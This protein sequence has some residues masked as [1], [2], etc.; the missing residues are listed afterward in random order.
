[1]PMSSGTRAPGHAAPMRNLDAA[2]GLQRRIVAVTFAFSREDYAASEAAPLRTP[3]S[4]CSMVRLATLGHVRK[5]DLGLIRCPG[6]RRALGLV[7][8]D[9]DY[10]S[11]RRYFSLGLYA[12]Q[13]RARETAAQVRLMSR[14][15]HGVTVQ[16]LASCT[17]A[18]HV[19]ICICSPNQ[20]MRMLQGYIHG[21]GPV[22]PMG[23]LG[24]QGVCAE[25]TVHPF[26]AG[27]PN[28][29][30]LC[31]NTRFSCAWEDGEL[32]VGLP[33]A[34]FQGMVDGV[35]A[36]IDAAESDAGK[37]AIAERSR[38]SGANVPIRYGTAYYL[39]P[40]APVPGSG[41]GGR[42]P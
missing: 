39:V 8:P 37:R 2:L 23:S 3:L 26:G 29:S 21:H 5:A 6:A 15:V 25:L 19:V 41:D 38:R 24:M 1:M 32:G 14:P 22:S 7:P 30:L 36:T 28:V 35:L 18:P 12:D 42:R 13:N 11:G 31:S 9:E 20:A 40:G 16:P 33:Y 4:Y 34:A 17:A 10:Q 27:L